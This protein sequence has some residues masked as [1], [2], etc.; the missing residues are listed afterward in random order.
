MI[1]AVKRHPN[2]IFRARKEQSLAL[3]VFANVVNRT[4]LGQPI[5]DQLPTL[6]PVAS[7]IDI[8]THIVD[9]KTADGS[10][11]GFFIDVRRGD[12]RDLAPPGHRRRRESATVLWPT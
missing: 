4:N 5:N 3:W 11:G 2:G 8:R 10:V 7:A 12:L 9:A 1:A 6:A